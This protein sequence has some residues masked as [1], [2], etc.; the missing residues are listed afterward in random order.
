M[1]SLL[2]NNSIII[3]QT[4][5]FRLIAYLQGTASAAGIVAPA[6]FELGGFPAA[7]K[8]LQQQQMLMPPSEQGGPPPDPSDS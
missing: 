5:N 8:L 7:A 4:E 2:N 6:G 3:E 1:Q